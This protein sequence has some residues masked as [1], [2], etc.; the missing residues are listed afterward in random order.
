[1]KDRSQMTAWQIVC[2]IQALHPKWTVDEHVA[3]LRDEEGMAIDPIWVARWLKNIAA[4]EDPQAA[5][6]PGRVQRS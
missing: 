3:Y 2:R 4:D 6:A 1:M 5:Q